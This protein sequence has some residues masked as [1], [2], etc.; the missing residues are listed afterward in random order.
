MQIRTTFLVLLI[1]FLT[2]GCGLPQPTIAPVVPTSTAFPTVTPNPRAGPTEPSG[3]Y[4]GQRPPGQDP[5]RFAYTYIKGELHTSP[6]FMP[7]GSEVYWSSQEP[8]IYMMKLEN[9]YWTQ[10]EKI[11]FS[12]SLTDYRDPFISPAGDKL[13]FLSKGK[14]PGSE[15][16]EKEN[17]WFVERVGDGWGDP[18]P[19]G[20]EVN[21]LTLHWQ[22]SVNNNGDIFFTKQLE[23]PDSDIYVSRFVN[24]RYGKAEKLG[25]AINTHQLE[26]TPYT[27]PDGSYLIFSRSKDTNSVSRLF[28]SYADHKGGWS[29]AVL[30]DKISYGL[31]P[32]VSPDGK[33]LFF[34]SSPQSIS[35]MRTDFIKVSGL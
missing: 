31:C 4:L 3:P 20:E 18:Q 7:D 12:D 32:V 5:I 16:P 27:A 11:A 15:L 33:Y 1:S 26:T 13:F 28:I 25:D 30:I 21:A 2:A 29:N 35:W 6:V 8:Q 24:G 34:L 17:V 23:T 22:I 14:L 9:S 19:L 10:P